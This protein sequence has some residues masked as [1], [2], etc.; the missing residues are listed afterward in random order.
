MFFQK[1]FPTIK[2][3]N[4]DKA[5]CLTYSGSIIT[6]LHKKNDIP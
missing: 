4:A 2:N 6:Q 5:K 3:L 1:L